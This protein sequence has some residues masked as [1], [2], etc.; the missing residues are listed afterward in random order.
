[1]RPSPPKAISAKY[2]DLSLPSEI[3][4]DIPHVSLHPRESEGD[5]VVVLVSENLM[6]LFTSID[7]LGKGFLDHEIDRVVSVLDVRNVDISNLR[8]HSTS[9]TIHENKPI[10]R[11]A[12]LIH[13]RRHDRRYQTK[14]P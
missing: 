13:N 8:K 6:K 7:M 12:Y 14:N 5:L 9:Y 1:M 2:F 4:H 10:I 3:K 11:N